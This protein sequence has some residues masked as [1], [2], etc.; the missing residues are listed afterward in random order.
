MLCKYPIKK[1]QQIKRRRDSWVLQLTEHCQWAL[2]QMTLPLFETTNQGHEFN[3]TSTNLAIQKK[4]SV[5]LKT[6]DIGQIGD[7][8]Y[9]AVTINWGFIV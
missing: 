5:L 9:G 8:V 6:F 4:I 3:L 1:H 7:S 2:T